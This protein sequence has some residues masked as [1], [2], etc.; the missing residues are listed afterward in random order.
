[1]VELYELPEEGSVFR[2]LVLLKVEVDDDS[3]QKVVSIVDLF[4]AKVIDVAPASLTIEVTGDQSKINGL[5]A[6][7]KGFNIIEMA[8]TGLTGLSRGISDGNIN[9]Q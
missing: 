6:M 2:E 4:R 9:N 1:M 7:M 3:R 8:R 5:L